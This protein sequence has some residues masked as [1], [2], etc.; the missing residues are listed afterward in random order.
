MLAKQFTADPVKPG[1]YS[2]PESTGIVV[3]SISGKRHI[4]TSYVERH[5]L[6]MRM[7]MRGFA[8]LTDGVSE[9]VGNRMHA[10]S[11][12]FMN[13]NFARIHRSLGITTP[14]MA[15]G[16]TD[17]VWTVEEIAGL[18]YDDRAAKP[19]DVTAKG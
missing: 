5:N 7:S 14:A 3:K 8:R 1:R 9:K 13:Y 10:V 15:A 18:L 4:V 12:H 6:T 19:T 11:L 2:P 16:V 17:H